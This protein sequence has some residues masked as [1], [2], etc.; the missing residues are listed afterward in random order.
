MDPRC[1]EIDDNQLLVDMIASG[2]AHHHVEEEVA[3]DASNTDIYRDEDM[4]PSDRIIGY[5]K[6]EM[7]WHELKQ[8]FTLPAGSEELVKQFTLKKMAEQFQTFKKNFT[9]VYIKQGKM[10]N[11]T[12]ELEKLR[13]HWDDFV[14][15]KCSD[16]GI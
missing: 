8:Q 5:K 15:Y 2:D 13:D 6:K 3:D 1:R 11:F 4:T 10:S 7:V 12:G 9:N 14:K 16:L